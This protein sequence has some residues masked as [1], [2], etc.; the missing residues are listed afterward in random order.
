MHWVVFFD[1]DCAFCSASA[2]TLVR[3]DSN[4]RISYAPLQ[5]KLA[6]SMGLSDCAS[7]KGGTMVVMR[8][9]EQRLFTR[10][11]AWI[12]VA[13]ALG[14]WWR[15][16]LIAKWIPRFL[17]DGVYRLVADNRSRLMPGSDVCALPDPELMKRLR[18]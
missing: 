6:A 7:E 13:R 4:A 5:G 9:P 2:R 1:G 14:G 10:S 11:D 16:F 17:R 8:E 15:I 12:E 3:L 18:E